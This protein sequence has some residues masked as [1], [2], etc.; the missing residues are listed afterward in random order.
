[1]EKETV[2]ISYSRSP[3]FFDILN[4][5][6]VVLISSISE[7]GKANI[8]TLT[9]IMPVSIDPPLLA[10][11]VSPER[12][13]HQLIQETGEFVVNIPTIEILDAVILCGTVSGRTHDKFTMSKLTPMRAKKVKPPIIG[14]C[15][16]HLE[17]KL[18][19]RIPMGDHTM[20]IGKIIEAYANKNVL[21]N[22]RYN[23][24]KAKV[25]CHVGAEE[26]TILQSNVFTV[27]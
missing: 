14:E 8:M 23:L 3:A 2:D 17:C 22:G 5:M 6:R 20:F 15:I 11:S 12:Y 21:S 26:F 27:H 25:V 7:M 1:M 13:T 10:I 9:W 16:A 19:D 18:Q 4:P 24:R